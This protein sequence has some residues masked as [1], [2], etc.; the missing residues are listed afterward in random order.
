MA[1]IKTLIV[2]DGLVWAMK[3]QNILEDDKFDNILVGSLKLAVE[4]LAN[5]KFDLIIL[6][7]IL[8]DSSADNTLN[9]I[10][11]SIS[12]KPV[13]ILSSIAERQTL[14]KALLLGFGDFIVKDKFDVD[15][16]H[17]AISISMERL[18]ATTN[19]QNEKNLQ[20]VSEYLD[21]IKKLQASKI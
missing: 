4:A 1:K 19:I 21:L 10:Y 3:I 11:S 6:D 18:K 13:V 16:L 5:T 15:V 2:E 20:L 17:H 9:V 12:V 14:E 7:L 8:P